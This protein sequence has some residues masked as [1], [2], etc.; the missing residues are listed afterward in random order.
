MSTVKLPKFLTFEYTHGTPGRFL[1]LSDTPRGDLVF[2]GTDPTDPRC[3]FETVEREGAFQTSFFKSTANGKFW[4]RSLT[5]TWR[6][7]YADATDVGA[8]DSFQHQ[9]QDDTNALLAFWSPPDSM[10]LRAYTAQD[11]VLG[12]CAF[13]RDVDAG[14]ADVHTRFRIREAAAPR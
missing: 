5:E 13:S 8:A 14:G 6:W 12:L 2:D 1:R 4:R 9:T 10:F 11:R 7:I 3:I